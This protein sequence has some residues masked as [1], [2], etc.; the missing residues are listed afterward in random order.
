MVFSELS[1]QENPPL[2]TIL[3]LQGRMEPNEV[4][5]VQFQLTHYSIVPFIMDHRLICPYCE[6]YQM[7][8]IS[9]RYRLLLA[10]PLTTD[11]INCI[12]LCYHICWTPVISLGP[13]HGNINQCEYHSTEDI[14]TYIFIQL[15]Y[16]QFYVVLTYPYT[17]PVECGSWFYLYT[18]ISWIKE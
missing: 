3:S 7:Q 5:G 18:H 17:Q 4:I 12:M 14:V 2:C 9:L 6:C 11:Y 15:I 10:L 16:C 1:R 13:L 8:T